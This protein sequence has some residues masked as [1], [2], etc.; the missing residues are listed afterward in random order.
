MILCLLSSLQREVLLNI[1]TS[2]LSLLLRKLNWRLKLRNSPKDFKTRRKLETNFS[3]VKKKYDQEISGFK[4]DIEDLELANQKYE[5]DRATKD[6][7]LRN[8][9]DE[10]SHQDELIN[11]INKEKKHLQEC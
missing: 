4:K 2:R 11:K 5:Q 8:L 6:H 10:I 7:Q 9:N 1:W 3:K